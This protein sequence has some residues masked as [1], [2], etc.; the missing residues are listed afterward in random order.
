V[1]VA[2]RA[3]RSGLEGAEPLSPRTKWR[4]ITLATLVIAPAVWATI[5]G[6]VSV[7][8]QDPNAPAGGPLIA[9][10]LAIVP[11]GFVV[12]AFLS[13]HPRAPGAVVRAM[14]LSL[15]VGIA[16]GAA[17]PDAV[18]PLVAG[19][20][21]GGLAALRA[22][23]G[24]PWQTRAIAVAAAT[25]L[26]FLLIQISAVA[27]VVAPALPF[28]CVGIADHVADERRRRAEDLDAADGA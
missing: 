18:T 15:L 12:L 10:G 23:R 20:G 7:S 28:T 22:D 3:R 27:L 4:A 6:I 21:A 1:S 11:F 14:A 2:R 5:A 17:V 19:L 25:L 9:F 24:H 8:S 13:E 16:V 26:V